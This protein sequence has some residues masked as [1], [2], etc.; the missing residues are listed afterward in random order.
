MLELAAELTTTQTWS[1]EL[2]PD[3]AMREALNTSI[4]VTVTYNSGMDADANKYDTDPELGLAL[5]VL[6]SAL[7]HDNPEAYSFNQFWYD[8]NARAVT[9][10]VLLDLQLAIDT[11]MKVFFELNPHRTGILLLVDETRKLAESFKQKSGLGICDD[12][13]GVYRM[14]GAVGRALDSNRSALFN[15]AL[16]TLDSLMLQA[17]STGSG[18]MINWIALDGLR[19]SKAE[20]MI[21]RALGRRSAAGLPI[22]ALI[23]L[24]VA[25]C[26][27]HPRTLES[28][29]RV[30]LLCAGEHK[31]SVDWLYKPGELNYVRRLVSSRLIGTSP[32]WAIR[33]AL[34]GVALPYDAVIEGSGGMT[35]GDAIVKGVFLNT[36]EADNK[37]VSVP[38]LSFLH[39]LR[40]AVALPVP[41][42]EAILGMAAQE[43]AALDDP[44]K[45]GS[46]F[47][48]VGFEGF[49][50][51]WLQLR[52]G[53][54]AT[55]GNN[56]GLSLEELFALSPEHADCS[57]YAFDLR[58]ATGSPSHPLRFRHLALS[59]VCFAES[60]QSRSRIDK[61]IADGGGVV[62]FS[63]NNPAF[64]ILV[65]VHEA[66]VD[67]PVAGAAV[68]PP[69]AIAI[70]ARFSAPTSK[71]RTTAENVT[72][73]VALFN[74][75]LGPGGAFAALGI[76]AD[77]VT[78][79]IMASRLDG[80]QADAARQPRSVDPFR[81][82]PHSRRGLSAKEKASFLDQ[83]VLVL[84][85]PSVERAL[86]PTLVDRA[87][88]LLSPHSRADAPT[89]TS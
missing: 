4:A 65:L 69:F 5:R 82:M 78:Y 8:W 39:L 68:P 34:N 36:V 81:P 12:S 59:D 6:F 21:M 52:F 54:I 1:T 27:R 30:L 37:I 29:V 2:C 42:R 88:F 72:S 70:E 41:L 85:R 73:K 64:D 23:A 15:V 74:E 47:G 24:S 86:T 55:A 3:Q 79:V 26:A 48:G 89:D 87:F 43:E 13:N 19:Q 75:Q 31:F 11:C 38:R 66:A 63:A 83:G 44:P 18:R 57:H 77:R 51:R 76:P 45:S 58:M 7:V 53:L 32:L 22:P 40:S 35:F 17:V 71:M 46:M 49:V 80:P 25:D 9:H 84:D 61:V 33:A 50:L 20:A 28:L 10:P 62:T 14:L 56:R 60:P 16:T 67:V